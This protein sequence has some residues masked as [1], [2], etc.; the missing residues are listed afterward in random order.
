M[1]EIVARTESG[2]SEPVGTVG[3]IDIELGVEG[4]ARELGQ[5]HHHDGRSNNE[6][7][8]TSEYSIS[9]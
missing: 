4:T 1:A 8:S 5:L 6:S 9:A 3:S 2:A 7:D